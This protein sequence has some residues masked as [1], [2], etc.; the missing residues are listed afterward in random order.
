M[1]LKTLQNISNVE[2]IEPLRRFIAQQIGDIITAI[3]GK[4]AV[5][6]NLDGAIGEL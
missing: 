5:N 2:G 3:N 4:I 1:K 6:E